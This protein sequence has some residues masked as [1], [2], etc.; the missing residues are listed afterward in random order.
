MSAYEPEK[1]ELAYSIAVSYDDSLGMPYSLVGALDTGYLFV[2]G[3]PI[4]AGEPSQGRRFYVMQV[5]WTRKIIPPPVHSILAADWLS[6]AEDGRTYAIRM[7]FPV[8]RE[9]VLRM[10]PKGNLYGGWTESLNIEVVSPDGIQQNTV[11]HAL[12]PDPLTP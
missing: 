3:R 10:G 8:G 11:T 4:L 5:T 12:T 1:L 2:Y 9:T 7:P 6:S